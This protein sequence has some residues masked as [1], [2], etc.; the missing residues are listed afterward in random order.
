MV[1]SRHDLS[2][3]GRKRPVPSTTVNV[4]DVVSLPVT[5]DVA[6][7]RMLDVSAVASC[8]PGLVPETLRPLGDGRYQAKVQ[9][10]AMGVTAT[11]EMTAQ[12]TPDAV[13][14]RLAVTLEGDD[15]RLGM[16]LAGTADLQL[17]PRST[18]G[19]QLAYAGTV[20]VQGRLAA[21][22]GP[23]ITAVVE[24]ML[25]RFVH[26]LSGTTPLRSRRLHRARLIAVGI[27]AW[28]R[29]RNRMR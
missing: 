27:T 16:R 22:G 24:N 3:W 2:A 6:W 26:S 7:A 13:N 25:H 23:V 4:D 18:A 8:L 19:T 9:A 15:Q 5:A 14:R 28:F 21:A 29:R 11:W 12:L 17:Q 1:K 20:T 10:T